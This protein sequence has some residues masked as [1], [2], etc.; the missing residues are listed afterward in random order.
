MKS[1]EYAELFLNTTGICGEIELR[2]YI[3]AG[4]DINERDRDGMSAMDIA[5]AAELHDKKMKSVASQLIEIIT[6]LSKKND[7]T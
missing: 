6:E 7:N 3:T 5:K 4:G 2:S 1:F